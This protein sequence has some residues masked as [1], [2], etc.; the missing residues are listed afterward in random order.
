MG[1]NKI[2]IEPIKEDKLRNITFNKRKHGLLKKATELS[3]LCNIKVVLFF[4]DL[5]NNLCKLVVPNE[6]EIDLRHFCLNF[7]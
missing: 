3:I 6:Q 1:R 4:T 2:E 5:H 7:K